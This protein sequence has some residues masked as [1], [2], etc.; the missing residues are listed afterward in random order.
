MAVRPLTRRRAILPM[1]PEIRL[2]AVPMII[3]K[4][5]TLSRSTSFVQKSHHFY[6][7]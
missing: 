5:P 6:Q 3:A 7:Q 2:A 4:L 1:R